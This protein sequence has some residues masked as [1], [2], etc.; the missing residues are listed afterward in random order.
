MSGEKRADSHFLLSTLLFLLLCLSS[1]QLWFCDAKLMGAKLSS[2]HTLAYNALRLIPTH[3]NTKL[4][5]LSLS[6]PL[7]HRLI[8]APVSQEPTCT[9]P[10]PPST[11]LSHSLPF[12]WLFLFILS[13]SERSHHL[14]PSLCLCFFLLIT[15]H[16]GVFTQ[17]THTYTCSSSLTQSR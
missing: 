13:C 8:R 12:F 2:I 11:L 14:F 5:S 15:R 9:R 7:T 17:K 3:T 4:F 1:V 16:C 6:P 10:P